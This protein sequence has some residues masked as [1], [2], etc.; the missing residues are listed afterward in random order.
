MNDLK[1]TF[2]GY[3]AET[4]PSGEVRHRVRVEGNPRKRIRIP[5]GPDDPAFSEHYYAA[6]A[7]QKVE[8]GPA[9]PRLPIKS[10]DALIRDYLDWLEMKVQAGQMSALTLKQR[11]SLLIRSLDTRDEFG[12]RIGDLH[13]DLPPA[14]FVL[15]RDGW[16]DKTGQADNAL[17]GFS[18]VYKWAKDR[19][20]VASNPV[21]GVARV[22]KSGGGAVPWSAADLRAFL[23][24]HSSGSTARRW[25]MLALFTAA[26]ISD[27]VRHG[28]QHEVIRDGIVWLDWQPIKAGSSFV[29]LP[30]AP[31][32]LH[33]LR[34]AKVEGKTYLLSQHGR[35][36][37]SPEGLR[38]MVQAWTGQAGLENRSQHGVRK[39]LGELLAEAGCS[40]HQIMSVMAHTKPATSAIYT[41]KADRRRMAALAMDGIKNIVL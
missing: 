21:L 20:K 16:G 31:Q 5:V 11:Q 18:A 9:R 41:E 12:E 17:K 22:H 8:P 7:G 35:P 32:L 34:A 24:R 4:L 3:L 15:M 6:R 33:E 38:N 19:G 28:R 39:A 2:R 30:V 29:S 26:R 37:R 14:A 25:L 13:F 23:D 1:V 40:Q 36:Y 10:A 27:T